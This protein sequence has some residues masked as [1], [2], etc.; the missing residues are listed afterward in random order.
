MLIAA[1]GGLF[2]PPYVIRLARETADLKKR[3]GWSKRESGGGGGR[4]IIPNLSGREGGDLGGDRRGLGLSG[5]L[6]RFKVRG[7]KW[8][9]WQW[10][11]NLHLPPSPQVLWGREW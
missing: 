11:R 2:V 6:S 3:S 5:F 10:F 4:P 9:R 1:G 8:S 7:R